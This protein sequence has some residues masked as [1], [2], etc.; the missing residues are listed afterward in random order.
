MLHIITP[1]YRFELIEKVY[2][3]I[4]INDDVIWHISYSSKRELPNLP[5][6]TKNKQ[7]RIYPVDCEDNDTPSKRNEILNQIKDGYFCFLDDDTTIYKNRHWKCYI[8]SFLFNRLY[9][10][11]N[12]HIQS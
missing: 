3:S 5:F 12:I 6:L 2:S 10:A 7:I 9:L 4:P 11:R 1:L 8:T